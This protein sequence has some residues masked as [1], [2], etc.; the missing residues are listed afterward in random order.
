MVDGVHPPVQLAEPG[1]V[2]AYGRVVPGDG[3][4]RED[5]RQSEH[6]EQPGIEIS[7]DTDDPLAGAL[8]HVDS[9]GLQFSLWWAAVCK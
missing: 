3:S 2:V 7:V 5:K 9:E 6:G 1:K 8:E 4:A